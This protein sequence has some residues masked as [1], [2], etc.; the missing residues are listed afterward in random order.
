E[1][2][3]EDFKQRGVDVMLAKPCSRAE[4]ESAIAGLLAA[5]PSTGLDVLLV[6]D[7]PVFARA[8]RDLL[9]LQGHQVTVVDSVAAA[10]QIGRA[11]SFDVVV[12]DDSLGQVSGAGLAQ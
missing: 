3:P 2:A 1:I 12:T 9:G 7:E 10:G 4:L 5:K 11:H 6:D 8:V